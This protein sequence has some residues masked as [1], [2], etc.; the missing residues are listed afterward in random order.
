MKR[1]TKY[2][3]LDVH[4]ARTVASVRE[5]GGRVIARCIVPTEAAALLALRTQQ[6]LAYETGVPNVVDPLGGSYYVEALTDRVEREALAIIDRIEKLGGM[7][8]CIQSGLIQKEIAAE[9]YRYQQRVESGE[10]IVVGVN[11]FSRPE[12]E[13]RLELYQ[14]DTAA[15]DRQ[16]ESLARVR[17]TRDNRRVAATLAKLREAARGSENLMPPISEAVKAYASVGEICAVL[18]EE[19]GTFKEPVGL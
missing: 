16:R 15:A 13:R 10:Q 12:P 11:R 5:P 7:V 17:A 3:A 19:F 2:V 9:A 18:R 1:T 8:P 4:Q 14:A 6:V